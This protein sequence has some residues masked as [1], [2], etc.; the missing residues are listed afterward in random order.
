MLWSPDGP[1]RKPPHESV[2]LL[3]SVEE[4]FGLSEIFQASTEPDFLL[5]TIGQ[6][7]RGAIERAYDWLLPII[8]TVETTISRLPSNASCFLLLKAYGTEGDE[9]KQLK[10]LSAPLLVHVRESLEGKYSESDS[11]NAFELLMTDV[12][13]PQ[14]ERRRCARRVLHDALEGE[15]DVNDSRQSWMLK[16]PHLRY[17]QS[18]VVGAVKHLVSLT[19]AKLN[20]VYVFSILTMALWL[21]LQ[22]CS[23]RIRKRKS[24]PIDIG[25]PATS[26]CI[27]ERREH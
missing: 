13:S 10:K 22:V 7:N 1:A 14:A 15:M 21:T 2:D 17:S 8:S 19:S 25:C 20:Y 6:T 4:S 23:R 12:A 11:V 16:I 27:L 5:M 3:L 9:R 24:S 26:F 18:L